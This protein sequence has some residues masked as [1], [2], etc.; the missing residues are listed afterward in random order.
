VI[1]DMTK[2]TIALILAVMVM[3]SLAGC[4]KKPKTEATT[5]MPTTAAAATENTAAAEEMTVQTESQAESELSIIR[6]DMFMMGNMAAVAYLGYYEG[7][8]LEEYLETVADREECAFLFEIDDDHYVELEGDELYCVIPCDEQAEV[9]VYKWVVDESNNFEGEPGDVMYHSEK[10]EPVL[11]KGNISDIV[12][13]IMV[14]VADKDER[15]IEYTPF[16]S[17]IDGTLV[18]PMYGETILDITPYE[19]LGYDFSFD[20]EILLLTEYWET[21][22][23]SSYNEIYSGSFAFREDGRAEFMYGYEGE[24]YSVFYE[25]K[26]YE[27]EDPDH[28]EDTYILE[29]ELIENNSKYLAEEKTVSAF[30]FSN[31]PWDIYVNMEY[32]EGDALFGIEDQTLYILTPTLG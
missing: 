10:G 32:I 27:S 28:P 13:N 12:P 14:E 5:A 30:R 4:G 26:F 6:N 24:I 22:A 17:G 2:R 3:L 1:I 18:K 29:L 25:G 8:E 21:E 23:Y 7:G 19:N 11:I 15:I 9:T 16:L 20:P 31:S